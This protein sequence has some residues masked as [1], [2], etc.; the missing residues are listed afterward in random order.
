MAALTGAV[1]GDGAR[2]ARELVIAKIRVAPVE[3]PGA[4]ALLH[5]VDERV[6]HGVHGDSICFLLTTCSAPASGLSA[7]E[8]E[9]MQQHAQRAVRLGA[10]RC[11][12]LLDAFLA[13]LFVGGVDS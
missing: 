2:A 13:L 8:S 12:D 3:Q 6:A 10:S 9:R 5:P 11:A 1:L 4:Q 7:P